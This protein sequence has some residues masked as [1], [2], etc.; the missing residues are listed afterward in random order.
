MYRAT[1]FN[2]AAKYPKQ[3]IKLA[4]K[5]TI[6]PSPTKTTLPVLSCNSLSHNIINPKQ[7]K[8]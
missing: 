5:Y 3:K 1:C 6:Q 8:R 7:Q 2:L 4:P